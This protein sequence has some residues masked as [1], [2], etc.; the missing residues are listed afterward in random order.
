MERTRILAGSGE[1]LPA[2]ESGG[3]SRVEALC[4]RMIR[5]ST[6]VD[7]VSIVDPSGRLLGASTIDPD[8]VPF[9]AERIKELYGHSF[10]GGRSGAGAVASEP[11]A[12]MLRF[13][14]DCR[15]MET[16]FGAPVY[17]ATF[18]MPVL[19]KRGRVV[20]TLRAHLRRE[21]FSQ[22]M[23][24]RVIAGGR[25]GIHLVT[26]HGAYFDVVATSDG[27]R[28]LGE[29]PADTLWLWLWDQHHS[30]G[31]RMSYRHRDTVGAMVQLDDLPTDDQ[32]GIHVLV[33]APVD[34]LFREARQAHDLVVFQLLIQGSLIA[35]LGMLL[36]GYLNGRAKHGQLVQLNRAYGRIAEVAR[37]TQNGVATLDEH[38]RITWVN[39]RFEAITGIT[40]ERAVG[41]AFPGL[42][43]LCLADRDDVEA[44][45]Q[46]L[47]EGMTSEH[48]VHFLSVDGR[49]LW[50]SL[51]IHADAGADGEACGS[52]IVFRDITT[53]VRARREAEES[54][55]EINSLRGALDKHSVISVTDARGVITDVNAGFCE[56]SGF[57]REELIGKTHRL[58]NSGKHSKG[59]WARMWSDMHAGRTWREVVC[60]QRKDG[61]SYWVDS[62]VIPYM[63]GDGTLEKC[64]SIRFDLTEQKEIERTLEEAYHAIKEQ[65]AELQLIIDS[66]PARIMAKDDQNRI[67][68]ANRCVADELGVR[69]EELEGAS[70]EDYY[71]A[72]VAEELY[73]KELEVIRSGEPRLGVREEVKSKFGPSR[74]LSV[75]KIPMAGS[76]GRMDRIL[77]IASDLTELQRAYEEL[78][79]LANR[80]ALATQGAGV[81]IW[82]Y[83]PEL[84]EL[85]WDETMHRIYGTGV[86]EGGLSLAWWTSRIHPDDREE[87]GREFWQKVEQEDQFDL[88]YRIRTDG[89]ETKNIYATATVIRNDE[90]KVSQILG[91]NK[92]VT[93]QYEAE[94]RLEQAMNASRIMMYDWD[95]Q[96]DETSFISDNYFT[97]LGYV[98]GEL[99]YTYEAYCAN[100]HPEDRER[101]RGLLHA[102]LDDPDRGYSTME[103]RLV[104]RDGEIIWV[105]SV[106]E[107]IE[108][109]EQGRPMR[110]V[111]MIID[112]DAEKRINK[113]LRS[114]V[115]LKVSQSPQQ[116]LSEV[117]RAVGDLFGTSYAGV[118]RKEVCDG[119]VVCRLLGAADSESEELG[120]AF[121]FAGSPCEEIERQGVFVLESGVRERF[122]DDRILDNLDVEGFAGVTLRD[123]HGDPIGFLTLLDKRPM[124]IRADSVSSMQLFGAR[125]ASELER[126]GIEEHLR[127]AR[128]AAEAANI[129]K[130]EF[131]ANMSHEIRTPM[132]AILGYADLL[133]DPTEE[134]SQSQ[135]VDS[136]Q[137]IQRNA[138]HLLTVINDILDM[139]RIE[140]GRM[141]VE[142]IGVTT[143]EVAEEVCSLMRSRAEGKGI[144]LEVA[145]DTPVPEEIRTDPTRLRQILINLVGNAIK[146]TEAGTITIGVSCV[147]D[148]RQMVFRVVDTGIGMTPDQLG[149]ISQFNAFSQADTSMARKYGGTGLGLRISNSLARLLGGEI[150]VTSEVGKGSTFTVVVDAGDLDGV[151][152]VDQRQEGPV[153]EDVLDLPEDFLAQQNKPRLP[154][155]GQR[156]LL[157]EDGPDNQRLISYHLKKAGAEVVLAENG[158]VACDLLLEDQEG[159][160][161]VL[162]DMQMP[163]MDGYSATRKLR[164][165]GFELPVV[166]LTAHA[167][168]HD[169][170]HC[171]DAGCDDY[172][173][174]PISKGEL[175]DMCV[176]WLSEEERR[177]A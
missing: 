15:V 41:C 43:E 68:Y 49:D 11:R 75:D 54:L 97:K 29:V 152:M 153:D 151:A 108:S 28:I 64:V 3:R 172:M 138:K 81:G 176:R 71:P 85:I 88:S 127:S 6:E 169:R 87:A 84:D 2:L 51:D 30:S 173:T 70:F 166:A 45:D 137:T 171:L 164:E 94:Y 40:S 101:I 106:G 14:T 13:K 149:V 150:R 46:A 120:V 126:L 157:A 139:S 95:I 174:K 115:E 58:V 124:V 57:S 10:D 155:K 104:K 142:R 170:D 130:S 83:N 32:Y 19:D 56:I 165:A 77:I 162:M 66:I 23:E 107:V 147:P 67:I 79:R 148:Q 175:I 100:I 25:G 89:G 74:P 113:A 123:S 60:N 116:T 18:S 7:T 27:D 102:F 177:V 110:L 59:F 105:R 4:N 38:Q 109:D 24:G 160:D 144:R 135:I 34:W 47:A 63:S 143:V 17:S 52:M 119:Q 121:P 91:V 132:T 55:R 122:R 16:L 92:D 33:T 93:R 158:R 96:R 112:I 114:V 1:L 111:G 78:D 31:K 99:P 21:R 134:I 26:D 168:D 86:R 154:L 129:A 69:A 146:F 161:L 159:V 48:D 145:Y 44:L 118:L 42:I 50:L 141:Q 61:T 140:A 98:P 90:G 53:L 80:L 167:M 125:A 12:G 35:L 72:E 156:I 5:L 163:E 65:Q 117:C 133:G 9:D 62:T 22:L 76:G 131:L 128:D 20:A 8:G 82:E 103:Y 136:I 73:R 39:G 37:R 36:R